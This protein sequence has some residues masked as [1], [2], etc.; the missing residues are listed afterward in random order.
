VERVVVSFRR[1]NEG[2]DPVADVEGAVAGQLGHAWRAV[3]RLMPTFSASSR[4][5]GRPIAGGNAPSR[6]RS[7][8]ASASWW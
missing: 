4:S 7:R 2:A 5:G 1:G 8:I 6:T 3:I